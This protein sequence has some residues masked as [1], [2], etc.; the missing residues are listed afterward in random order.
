MM[1]HEIRTPMNA[2]IGMS[3]LL[4]NTELDAEQRDFAETIRVSSDNLLT[5]INDILDFSKI[6]AGKMALEEQPFDLRECVESAMDLLRVKAA[7]KGLEL[8]YEVAPDVPPAIVGDVTRLR[9][10]L[11]N[12]LSNAVKFTETGEVVV[13]VTRDTETRGPGDTETVSASPHLPVPVSLHFA[14]RDT[15]IGIPADRL[16]RLFQAF[17]QL[18]TSTSRRYGGTGLGLA[19][20]KRLAEMMN[21]TMWA[22]SAGAGKGSTFHFVIEAQAAPV[23]TAR[24]HLRGEQPDLAGRRLLIVDDNATNR[25]I[26]AHAGARVGDGAARHRVT[27]R[28][29]GVAAG[30]RSIR[31]GHPGHA[32]ARDDRRRAGGRDPRRRG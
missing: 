10:I 31:R 25:R 19:V 4:M 15:G 26:L 22:E 20:S 23:V 21:G 18:D 1:S 30:R 28:S 16:D 8:A 29:V 24:P 3:G 12:L 7:E 5:I 2:I 11:V 27:R 32:H 6:E 17:S 9:Q 14:V 13:T